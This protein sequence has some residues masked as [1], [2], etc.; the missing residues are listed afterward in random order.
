MDL[1]T[2]KK[3][4]IL[5][6]AY[7]SAQNM[8]TLADSKANISLTIQTML[9]GI[10][11]GAS[12]LSNSF[13][14]VKN[15]I[16]SNLSLF[17]IYILIT[18]AFIAIAVIGIL[19]TIYVFKPRQ[20]PEKS[21]RERKGLLY[22]GHVMKYKSPADYLAAIIKIKEEDL[23]TEYTQQ[24]YTM[25]LIVKEKM[26]YLNISIYFLIFN[27]AFTI[28]FLVLSGFINLM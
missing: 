5:S 25:S 6:D 11:L 16:N 22:F 27:I 4:E 3:N 1:D 18:V 21:E 13:A 28:I 19:A 9:V 10:G 24:I 12:L 2:A 14:N 7:T 17:I 26:K 23:L 20:A 15:L 8:I